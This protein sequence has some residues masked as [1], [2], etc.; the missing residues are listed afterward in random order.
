M[1]SFISSTFPNNNSISS[2]YIFLPFC[3]TITFLLLPV[4]NKNPSSSK[5][6]TSPELNHLFTSI[7]CT[8]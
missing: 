1:H 7:T 8:T 2:G 4:I 6:P 3:V 5:Y